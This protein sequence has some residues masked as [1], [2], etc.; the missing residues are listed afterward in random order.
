[1]NKNLI[2][3]AGLAA[4]AI[5]TPSYAADIT[6]RI[7]GSTA[8]RSNVHSILTTATPSGLGFTNT[9]WTTNS[10]AAAASASY[11]V[12]K[13]GTPGDEV[14]IL[15]SWSGSVAGVQAVAQN[16]T[17]LKWLPANTADTS[18]TLATRQ[19]VAR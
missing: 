14:T 18:G 13:K 10:A 19:S 15:T 1:M 7:T 3:L 5:A 9:A 16:L 4:F 2:T 6:I 11:H 8:M 17:G 12:Y